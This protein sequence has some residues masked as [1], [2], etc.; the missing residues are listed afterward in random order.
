MHT[1][2]R[3]HEDEYSI[4]LWLINHSGVHQFN[5]MFSVPKLEQAMAAV[6]AMNGGSRI[7]VSALKIFNE[8][9]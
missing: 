5:R 2:L 4:G 3:I 9:E 6:N 7:S 1:W 8:A